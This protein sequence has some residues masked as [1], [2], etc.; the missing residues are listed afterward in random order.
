MCAQ[1]APS[2]PGRPGIT[3][4]QWVGL[5]ALVLLL[6][7][8]L[9]LLR[10]GEP[11]S[12]PNA[13]L[14]RLPFLVALLVSIPIHEFSHSLVATLMG[15][16][17]PRR[18]GRLTLNPLKHLDPLG[19]LLILIGPIG[20]G[21][22]MPINP[23]HMRRPELGWALSSLAGPV[24]NVLAAT[25]GTVVLAL[26]QADVGVTAARYLITFIEI[27]VALAVFNLLPLPPLDGFGFVFGLVPTPVKTVLL[28]IRQYGPLILLA[29]ILV[30]TF[31]PLL[32]TFL[33]A[34]QALIF[35]YLQEV[36]RA[37]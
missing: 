21:R 18:A 33:G 1:P 35:T 6:L 32:Y 11:Q 20:W 25:V 28:P 8:Q 23:G 2:T 14:A 19:T 17:T 15:D 16:D 3:P 30:P 13:L 24:S 22:P 36:A 34:G 5:A 27:N 9:G 10:L 31:Q 4:I 37:V 7:N 12:A 29:L 26:I